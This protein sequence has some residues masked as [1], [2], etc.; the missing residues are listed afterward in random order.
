VLLFFSLRLKSSRICSACLLGV[1]LDRTDKY[2]LG[3][4]VEDLLELTEGDV[5]VAIAINQL[6]GL[7]DVLI[8][9]VLV[10]GPQQSAELFQIKCALI[11]IVMFCE[12][13]CQV[14]LVRL[15]MLDEVI[16]HVYCSAAL[17]LKIFLDRLVK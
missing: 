14:Y 3:L 4:A 1:P 12:E 9:D 6:E 15:D 5:P 13:F 10:D 16:Q 17:L 8:R 7:L 2:Q 11:P